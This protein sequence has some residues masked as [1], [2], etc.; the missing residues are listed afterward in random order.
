LPRLGA[1]GVRFAKIGLVLVML[2]A[3]FV[4]AAPSVRAATRDAPRA[5]RFSYAMTRTGEYEKA[6]PAAAVLTR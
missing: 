2:T 6:D 5:G 1:L 3:V 4:V